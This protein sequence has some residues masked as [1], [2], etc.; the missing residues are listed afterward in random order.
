MTGNGAAHEN[1][2]EAD[3]RARAESDGVEFFFAMFVDM[4]GKPCAKMIPTVALD[5]LAGGGAGFAGFAAGPM[6][7]SPADPDI[8]AMPD[9]SSY[10]PAPWR[11]GLGIIQCDPHV[12]GEPWPF[13]PRVILRR[14]LERLA[15][16]G[17]ALKVGAEAE[18]FL[19]RRSD[20][21]SI[22]VADP[23]DRAAALRENGSDAG[24][25]E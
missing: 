23:Q 12:L 13:A 14:Q 16:A 6:G 25:F 2:A 19:V 1:T 22:A 4:H 8:L 20:D 3:L 18:Y 15:N 17:Y 11:P 7:Q 9:L 10:M 24:G 5:V 21:G